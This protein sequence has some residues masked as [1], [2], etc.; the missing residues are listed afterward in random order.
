MVKRAENIFHILSKQTLTCKDIFLFNVGKSFSILD[1][2][3]NTLETIKDGH[4]ISPKYNS[5]ILNFKLPNTVMVF[6]NDYPRTN[7]FSSDRWLIFKI[8]NNNLVEKT[9][10]SKQ[11]NLVKE[12]PYQSKQNK[13]SFQKFLKMNLQM[14]LGPHYMLFVRL[15][16]LFVRMRYLT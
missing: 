7:A 8:S 3:Y 5:S 4:C 2:P 12:K 14:D 10:Q 11:N 15:R 6:S 13:S 16:I 1:C 9:Y